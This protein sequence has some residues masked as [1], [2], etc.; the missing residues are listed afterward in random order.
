MHLTLD[1]TCQFLA[2]LEARLAQPGTYNTFDP[3]VQL[4]VPAL[5]RADEV[6]R[7][8]PADV[9][10]VGPAPPIS[11]V[12][13]PAATAFSV[14]FPGEAPPPPTAPSSPPEEPAYGAH[15]RVL[16]S[17]LALPVTCQ[18]HIGLGHCGAHG[19][20]PRHGGD[21]APGAG[22]SGD[23]SE[24][25]WANSHFSLHGPHLHNA[26]EGTSVIVLEA[27][28]ARNNEKLTWNGPVQQLKHLGDVL[29]RTE[30][31]SGHVA[32]A[33]VRF[34]PRTMQ[35][36]SELVRVLQHDKAVAAMRP[37]GDDPLAARMLFFRTLNRVGIITSLVNEF[38]KDSSE[39]LVRSAITASAHA[40]GQYRRRP[41][42]TSY[43]CLVRIRDAL[44][45]KLDAMPR[46]A[47]G[48][49]DDIVKM[50]LGTVSGRV[51]RG[52]QSSTGSCVA[53]GLRGRELSHANDFTDEPSAS[54][55][56]H[57]SCVT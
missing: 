16:Q 25:T 46:P 28:M 50:L 4:L 44:V 57:S 10:L 7:L 12:S 54:H 13:T 52:I 3:L 5:H 18:C 29:V 32:R 17:Q 11:M 42:E 27:L 45:A 23:A 55:V 41:D 39:I 49:A 20:A 1:I 22:V 24:T 2:F 38:N 48:T 6:L 43:S 34:E 14:E 19:C 37:P 8:R 36:I 26:S 33:L 40:F 9:R 30:L 53:F 21:I 35:D 51:L 56:T 47:T 15:R 31:W